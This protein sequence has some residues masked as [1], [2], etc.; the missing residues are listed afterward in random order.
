[1]SIQTLTT[2]IVKTLRDCSGALC[3]SLPISRVE[4]DVILMPPAPPDEANAGGLMEGQQAL[5]DD[6]AFFSG[7]R[8][9]EQTT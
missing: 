9:E 6:V 4:V 8:D 1:M 3:V 5:N 7:C 2:Y